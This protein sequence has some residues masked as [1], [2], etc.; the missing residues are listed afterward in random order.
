MGLDKLMLIRQA[1]DGFESSSVSSWKYLVIEGALSNGYES[2]S[3][4]SHSWSE[5]NYWNASV[6]GLE[7]SLSG[8]FSNAQNQLKASATLSADGAVVGCEDS[9]GYSYSG[10]HT[11]NNGYVQNDNSTQTR[12]GTSDCTYGELNPGAAVVNLAVTFEMNLHGMSHPMSIAVNAQNKGVDSVIGSAALNYKDG[13]R[14]N[15]NYTGKEGETHK[16]TLTNHN[17]VVLA[18]AQTKTSSDKELNGTISWQDKQY[19]TVDNSRGVRVKYT[20]GTT[21]YY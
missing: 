15:M 5:R 19:A 21:E 9:D 12:Y 2:S 16:A 14:L 4:S 18:L 17:N 20:D 3:T 13:Q 8:T 1:S 11:Y 6:S 10:S 7:L